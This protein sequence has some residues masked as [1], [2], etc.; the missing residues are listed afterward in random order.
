VVRGTRDAI[1]PQHWA[2]EAAGLVPNGRLVVIERAAHTTNY[3]HPAWLADVVWP[4]LAEASAQ[5]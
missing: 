2:E 5:G 3:S 4:F 1:V